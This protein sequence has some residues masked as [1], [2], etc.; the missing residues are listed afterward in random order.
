MTAPMG[1][2]KGN[3]NMIDETDTV[4]ARGGLFD[5]FTVEPMEDQPAQRF[6]A[7]GGSVID[8]TSLPAPQAGL[9]SNVRREAP[10]AHQR[11]SV[12]GGIAYML[13]GALVGVVAIGAV[14]WL[15]IR[16]PLQDWT[17]FTSPL[18][19]LV[20]TMVGYHYGRRDS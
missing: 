13:A 9:T 8:E 20:A 15:V 6:P 3:E 4:E 5:S 1:S 19:T 10:L 17:T 14:G 11:E 16:A 18:F 2:R 12:R 7:D